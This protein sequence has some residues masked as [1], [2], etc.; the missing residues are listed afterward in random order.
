M[1]VYFPPLAKIEFGK[2]FVNFLS[3][4]SWIISTAVCA[5]L[6]FQMQPDLW[7]LSIQVFPTCWWQGRVFSLWVA[8]CWRYELRELTS[9]G[10]ASTYL[11]NTLPH[12]CLE[13]FLVHHRLCAGVCL[14]VPGVGLRGFFSMKNFS[15][16][17]VEFFFA[18]LQLSSKIF[19][20]HVHKSPFI[21]ITRVW[22]LCDWT[23]F[24]YQCNGF[25]LM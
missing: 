2:I 24:G 20:G 9:L 8:F 17:R 14:P 10:L 18:K 15:A 1:F 5:G 22:L 7:Y 6:V 19:V 4:L 11:C 3:V 13:Y 23:Y 21:I 16:F 12:H 25:I